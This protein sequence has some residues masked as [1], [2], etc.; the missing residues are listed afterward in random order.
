MLIPSVKMR[1]QTQTRTDTN[2][3]VILNAHHPKPGRVVESTG[4]PEKQ[5]S[6]P[7][8]FRSA[9]SR[10]IDNRPSTAPSQPQNSAASPLDVPRIAIYA[11]ALSFQALLKSRV[12][13]RK[14]PTL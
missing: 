4:A 13:I 12:A 1:P 5:Q 9:S 2:A 3:T 11:D 7:V 6:R 14:S 10:D 8:T